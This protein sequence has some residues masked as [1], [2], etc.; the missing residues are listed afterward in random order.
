MTWIFI[1]CSQ[2]VAIFLNPFLIKL[3]HTL[4]KEGW[5]E[6]LK[7]VNMMST[8]C[9]AKDVPLHVIKA[10]SGV[11]IYLHSFLNSLLGGS[12]K[13]DSHRS[14]STPKEKSSSTYWLGGWVDPR[15]IPCSL[16]GGE[17]ACCCWEF[18]HYPLVVQPLLFSQFHFNHK[19]F[20]LSVFY[21]L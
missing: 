5:I 13:S 1:L 7:L 16:E 9:N 4:L 18:N 14:H 17:I 10:Y 6:K 12:E 19:L 11:E 2:R 15:A 8:I 21:R 3:N 20:V